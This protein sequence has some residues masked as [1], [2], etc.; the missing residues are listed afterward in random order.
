MDSLQKKVKKIITLQ[1]DK[2]DCGV[3]ALKMIIRWHGADASAEKLRIESGTTDSGTTLLGLHQAAGKFHLNADA[4]QMETHDL[5][6]L[7]EPCILHTLIDGKQLH[8]MVF[9]GFNNDG[10]AVLGDPAT[11]LKTLNKENLE[12]IWVSRTALLLSPGKNFRKTSNIELANSFKWILKSVRENIPYLLISIAVGILISILSLSTSVFFQRLID[13]ILPNGQKEL[14]IYGLILL[15]IILTARSLLSYLRQFILFK[16]SK[17]YNQKI[18]VE[19]LER[20]LNLPKSFYNSRKI[21]DLITRINDTQKIQNNLNFI[22]GNIIIDGLII[23]IS[24]AAL[25]IY[26]WPIGL[27]MSLFIPL[28]ILILYSYTTKL[29]IGQR[30]VM[31]DYA[32]MESYYINTLSGLD[33]IKEFG[34]SKNFLDVGAKIFSRYQDSAFQL[35]QTSNKLTLKVDLLICL[36]TIA[37]IGF[38]A[39][40]FF[41]E[42]ITIGQM[43]ACLS[44]LTS[45]IPSILRVAQINLHLQEIDISLNRILE[46]TEHSILEDRGKKIIFDKES[47]LESVSIENVSF[48]YPGRQN[49]FSELNIKINRGDC[50]AIIGHNGS[51]KSTFLKLLSGLHLPSSGKISINTELRTYDIQELELA[52]IIATVPQTIH[53]FQGNIYDNIVLGSSKSRETFEPFMKK[54]GFDKYF[55]FFP[56]GYL[57]PISEDAIKLSGGQLQILALARALYSD[58]K[59]LILDECTSSLDYQSESF[60]FS[61]LHQVQKNENKTI[62]FVSHQEKVLQLA[63]KHFYLTENRMKYIANT[64]KEI[65]R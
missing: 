50:V 16:F 41:Q 2:A 23:T 43:V 62:I 33:T 40:I 21:G 58:P 60:I 46:V 53:I 8:Y 11:G 22:A 35:N 5:N 64:L 51:G 14:V 47:E 48:S 36:Q 49:I 30:Q 13:N 65:I 54:Y 63:N 26:S 44:I 27:L 17:N 10:S 42:N 38:G 7:K 4:Y 6:A 24:L 9:F 19:F 3:A 29:A 25:F 61:T 55:E 34:K 32:E 45:S 37:T 52:Q 20:M 1:Q 31:S 56:L 59:L 57:T 18:T 12:R 39:F 28:A 15:F